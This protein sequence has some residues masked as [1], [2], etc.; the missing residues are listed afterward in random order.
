MIDYYETKQH[1]I[2][3][4]MVL[5]AYKKVQANRGSAG[6]DD[7]SLEDFKLNISA[8]LYRIWNRMTSG[9][10]YPNAVKQV[11]IP[12]KSGGTRSL[13]I[14]TVSDR[15]AQ[16]LVKSYLEAN[17]EASFHVDSYGY[18]PNKSAHQ[19]LEI[20]KGRCSYYSW[21]LDIDIKGFFDN[22][23]H[24][25]MLKALKR[26]TQEKWVM[27]YVERWLKAGVSNGNGIE[28]RDKGTPQGGVISPLLANIFLH[29]AFDMWMLKGYSR[30]P[31]E[32][33][34]DDVIIHCSGKEQALLMKLAI[35]KR[36]KECKL[37]LNE[38]K[39]QIVY[40]R[41]QIHKEKYEQVSFDFLGYTFR[42]RYCPTKKGLSLLFTPCMSMHAKNDVREKVRKVI[43]RS[44][45]GTVQQLAQVLNQKV[46]GW[47]QYYCKYNKYTTTDLWYWLNGK[48]I[49]WVMDNR[50][51]GKQKAVKWLKTIYDTNPGMFVHWQLSHPW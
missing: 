22:I 37:E 9:S 4:K 12:K 2:T 11:L 48:M 24:E 46:R 31:F 27:K 47:F 26:Y 5:D 41:N 14:P 30:I 25:L 36:M 1:P 43:N 17:V 35:A 20:A 23:D 18:R 33:Y 8:N 15:I 34:C 50:R 19:A 39:T 16:Q 6:I 32:R 51:F 45:K 29:F 21:V 40:C 44:F 38:Q 3:K 42:P 28:N 7:Q 49:N 13:V 10:Y